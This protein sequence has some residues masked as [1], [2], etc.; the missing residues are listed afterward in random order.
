MPK[1]APSTVAVPLFGKR[2][3]RHDRSP[4]SSQKD[5]LPLVGRAGGQASGST[6]HRHAERAALRQ[7]ANTE[8]LIAFAMLLHCPSESMMLAVV[9]WKQECQRIFA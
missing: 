8:Q 3:Q 9:R 1:P 6:G 5:L 4:S 2:E 7:T